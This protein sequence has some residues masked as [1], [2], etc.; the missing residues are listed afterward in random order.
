ME[1]KTY[2]IIPGTL[3][4]YGPGIAQDIVPDSRESLVKNFVAFSGKNAR[5]LLEQYGPKPG[6]AVQ[7]SAPGEILSVWDELIR[8]G[9]CDTPFN[10]RIVTVLLEY[11]L[12]KIAETTIP[13]GSVGTPAFAT[14]QR[15][16]QWIDEH[17]L[18]INSL[19]QLAAEC[20]IDPAYLCRLFQRFDHQSPYQCLIG[21]KMRHATERLHLP[22]MPIKQVADE[23]GYADPAHFSRV[24]KR[25]EGLSPAQFVRFCHR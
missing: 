4:S 18:K 16:R 22:G 20:H 6:Q 14:Y 24:F 10:A 19:E 2:E 13:F 1:G 17:G 9:L 12:L 11:L 23:L 25:T 21:L 3:F 5:A 8:N 7:T 15:C